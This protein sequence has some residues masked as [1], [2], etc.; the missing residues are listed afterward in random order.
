MTNFPRQFTLEFNCGFARAAVR[1]LTPKTHGKQTVDKS[2]RAQD[3]KQLFAD[4]DYVFPEAYFDGGKNGS[5]FDRNCNTILR[6]WN[7]KWHPPES[8]LQ[9]E[10]I[11][12]VESWKALPHKGQHTLARCQAC[13]V[14]HGDIQRTFPEGP[15][16]EEALLSEDEGELR[17]IGR[18]QA[19]ME[20]LT[21]VNTLFSQA[22]DATFTELLLRHGKQNLQRK[23]TA[24]EKKQHLRK[25]YRHCRDK[26]NE[27]LTKSTAIA[28][29]TEDESMR[30]YQRKR[31]QQYFEKSPPTKQ[32]KPKSHSPDFSNVV[33]DKDQVLSDLQQHLQTPHSAINWSQF[34][35]DHAVPGKIAG[36]VLKEFAHTS[37]IDTSTLDG[38]ELGT[39]RT[40]IHK[41]RLVGGE[42]S[43]GS[44]P[45]PAAVREEWKKLVETGELSLGNPC[46]PYKMMRFA[47]KEGQLIREEVTIT[48]RKF[49]L[50]E[51]R[52]HLLDQHEKYMRLNTDAEIDNMSFADI[53]T[54][55]KLYHHQVSPDASVDNLRAL[56]KHHQ[57]NRSL[58]LW[59]DH[60]TLLGLGCILMTVH[61]AYDP[62]VFYTHAECQRP[63]APSVQS[64]VEQPAI[65]LLA[66]GSSSAEDQV[67]LLQDRIDCL[68]DLPT[69]LN[70]SKGIKIRDKL[71]FF[72]GDH[73][74]QQFERGTQQ[75]GTYKCG[76]CGVKDF[77]MQDMAHTLHRPRRSL[78][79]LQHIATVGQAGKQPGNLKPFSNLRVAALREELCARGQYDFG[80]K[81]TCARSSMTSCVACSVS[82]HCCCL[83]HNSLWND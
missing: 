16:Y 8:R 37:G 13:L 39:Y 65:Y 36:Q 64:V 24:L 35:R 23:P 10:S 73:P 44:T 67:A 71:K 30:A 66:A 79:D 54:L 11:F 78:Q 47:T 63:N 82:Q 22:F 58:I 2:K 42:I 26:E 68:L 27:A 51:I 57:R 55:C 18:K 81:Q 50:I 59:H 60:G 75:G 80:R 5:P 41:R 15:H 21:K 61:V 72:I 48:G 17:R 70:T 34:A 3:F 7:K 53:C 40:R 1:E 77:M 56:I 46:V 9:Y 83:I 6:I 33:W 25:I 45:T 43:A 31:R 49:P 19:T 14:V 38:K 76:S 74:A 20:T 32:A 28:V 69:E 29:L 4:A 62:G 12:S 52:Q